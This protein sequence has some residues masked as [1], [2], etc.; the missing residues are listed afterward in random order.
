[1]FSEITKRNLALLTDF[2]ELL[3]MEG[4]FSI[5]K[6]EKVQSI[7][8]INVTAFIPDEW[9]GTKEQKMIEYKRLADVKNETELDYIIS[10]WQDR[11][12]KAPESVENLIK[13]IKLRLSASKCKIK[14]IRETPENLRIYTP[15]NKIEWGI[16]AK[17]LSSELL[18][19]MKFT[20]APA[21]C[22]DG[23]SI[24]LLNSKFLTFIE[25]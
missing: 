19:D 11:F 9:V 14:L 23:I 22:Q 5:S 3:M 16:I 20:I 24:L 13:L 2:Y 25:I 10:E 8:D 12:S 17:N 15:F 7:V 4:Y 21:T 18:R 6:K 1:M